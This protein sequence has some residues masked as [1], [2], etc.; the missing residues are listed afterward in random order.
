MH[1]V[2]SVDQWRR[3]S[4]PSKL[5]AVG[6]YVGIIAL[7]VMAVVAIQGWMRDW[8]ERCPDSTITLVYLHRLSPVLDAGIIQHLVTESRYP[9]VAISALRAEMAIPEDA[10]MKQIS[11][12]LRNQDYRVFRLVVT[13]RKPYPVSYRDIRAIDIDVDYP[14]TPAGTTPTSAETFVQQADSAEAPVLSA[15]NIPQYETRDFIVTVRLWRLPGENASLLL[16][17]NSFSALH[18]L[19]LPPDQLDEYRALHGGMFESSYIL[20]SVLENDYLSK[21]NLRQLSLELTDTQGQKHK[22]KGKVYHRSQSG[23]NVVLN[24]DM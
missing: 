21:G 16:R 9:K 13:N 8:W 23:S 10:V 7:C 6:A 3:W 2:P 11:L 4:L 15:I 20:Y 17:S 19:G 24:A 22:V 12:M 1:L 14:Q 5:T 18:T